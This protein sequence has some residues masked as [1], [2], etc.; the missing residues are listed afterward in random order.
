MCDCLGWA[1]VVWGDARD[2]GWVS[3]GSGVT[4]LEE[5]RW[6]GILGKELSVSSY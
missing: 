6:R 2:V 4:F 1:G 5:K 3:F